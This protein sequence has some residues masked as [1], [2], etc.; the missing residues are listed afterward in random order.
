MVVDYRDVLVVVLEDMVRGASRKARRATSSSCRG[1]PWAVPGLLIGCG[2][3]KGR[4][5][6][7]AWNVEA[8]WHQP[9]G[10][11]CPERCE[12]GSECVGEGERERETTT[13][14]TT[15]KREEAKRPLWVQRKARG[16]AKVNSAQEDTKN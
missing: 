10:P 12:E 4:Q 2:W 11:A 3:L 5:N 15:T 7:L 16:I 9:G 13:T 8:G 1:M 14:T 6:Q